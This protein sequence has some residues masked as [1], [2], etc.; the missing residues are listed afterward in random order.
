MKVV[1][2]AMLIIPLEEFLT[3]FPLM[4]FQTKATIKNKSAKMPKI[5]TVPT[6]EANAEA[7]L[8]KTVDQKIV[9]FIPIGLYKLKI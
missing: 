4:P 1:C 5:P 7:P 3:A 9:W 2:E 8:L 6:Q